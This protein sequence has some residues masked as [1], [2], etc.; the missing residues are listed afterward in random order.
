MGMEK[1]GEKNSILNF[2]CIR[3]FGEIQ[4]QLILESSKF[5]YCAFLNSAYQCVRCVYI[6]F[7]YMCVCFLILMIRTHSRVQFTQHLDIYRVPDFL[8]VCVRVLHA[9]DVRIVDRGS[10]TKLQCL[11]AFCVCVSVCMWFCYVIFKNAAR[12]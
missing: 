7:T 10:V 8:F 12:N 9:L 1:G 5:S 4:A 11:G 6:I 3:S 2:N